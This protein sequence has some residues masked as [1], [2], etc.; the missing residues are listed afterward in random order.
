[1]LSQHSREQPKQTLVK[2]ATLRFNI[3][4]KCKV[5]ISMLGKGLQKTHLYSRHRN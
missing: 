1:M 2:V 5:H 3:H 4:I